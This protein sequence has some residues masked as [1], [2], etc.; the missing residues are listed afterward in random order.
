MP[1]I[2]GAGGL[3]G[4]TEEGI[5]TSCDG[6]NCNGTHITHVQGK[7]EAN[8]KGEALRLAY[9]V[10]V[11]EA[12]NL[13][14][15]RSASIELTLL[16]TQLAEAL[17][18]INEL[19]QNLN[20]LEEEHDYLSQSVMNDSLELENRIELIEAQC[21]IQNP[22]VTFS[23]TAVPPKVTE[24]LPD[25][26][27]VTL[28]TRDGLDLKAWWVEP[29]AGVPSRK[30]AIVLRTS[31]SMGPGY[32]KDVINIEFILGQP[33]TV[34][35][36]VNRAAR[37]PFAQ[38]L[39][40][41]GFHVLLMDYRGCGGNP[42]DVPWA[43]GFH[44]ELERETLLDWMAAL[45]VL[46]EFGFRGQKIILCEGRD[47]MVTKDGK[48]FEKYDTIIYKEFENESGSFT[49]S[50]IENADSVV[51]F[52]DAVAAATEMNQLEWR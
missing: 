49:E 38:E 10:K 9:Q 7:G 21:Q 25:G 30:Q 47:P 37:A 2:K 1:R 39:A 17:K 3:Y 18:K 19:E 45:D 20:D 48:F 5:V 36:G 32:Q 4:L 52:A 46:A 42:G 24:L 15:D 31:L 23:I 44:D 26:E 51:K 28:R 40:D 27:E 11:S 22:K 12:D 34:F 35:Q 16:K 13:V 14:T 43:T 50:L 33:G 8:K 6:K 29:A 41:K